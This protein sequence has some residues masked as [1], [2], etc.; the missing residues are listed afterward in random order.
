MP[1]FGLAGAEI[2]CE[3]LIY[4]LQATGRY[5]IFV[6]SLFDFHS[7]IT[8]R[9]ENNGVKIIYLG[10]KQGLDLAIIPKLVKIMRKYNIQIVHT[11]RYVMQYVIPAAII[12]KVPVRIH[13]IHNIASKEVSNFRQKLAY[14]F[15]KKCGVR[16]VSISPVVQRTVIER[17][18]LSESDSPIVFNGTDLGKCSVKTSYSTN[19][20]FRFVHIGRFSEQK[21]HGIMIDVAQRLKYE[22]YKFTI[23]FV[24]GAGNEK[25]REEE[26]KQKG[27]EDVI[28]FSGLQDNVYLFLQMSD[29]FIL[30]SLYEGMPVTLVEAMGCGMPIIASAVGGVPDMIEHDVSGLLI[31]PTINELYCAMVKMMTSSYSF[32]EKLGNNALLRSNEFSDTNMC[33]GYMCIYGEEL[34]KNN[35]Y[36]C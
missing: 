3:T 16:P 25:E 13:T 32:R 31:R 14:L 4:K 26:V 33:Q 5:Q 30:P 36:G 28:V 7:S 15:Y 22:G 21:N 29:C 18:N 34:K 1:E 24:G 17:Y 20:I 8:D 23:N 11:H 35:L 10:K 19:E 27:L 9:M 6:A 12:S 2:M